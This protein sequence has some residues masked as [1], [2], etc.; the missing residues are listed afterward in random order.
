M[1]SMRRGIA[2]SIDADLLQALQAY[3]AEYV[4]RA[5]R[6]EVGDVSAADAA[7]DAMALQD[8]LHGRAPSVPAVA[9][10]RETVKVAPRPASTKAAKAQRSHEAIEPSHR[11]SSAPARKVPTRSAP[12][13]A[14]PPRATPPKRTLPPHQQ[15]SAT[16]SIRATVPAPAQQKALTPS[17]PSPPADALPGTAGLPA[18]LR[19]P[20]K[21]VLAEARLMNAVERQRLI[22][23]ARAALSAI[24]KGAFPSSVA[25][26]AGDR[27]HQIIKGAE[28][29]QMTPLPRKP[30][31]AGS[32]KRRRKRASASRGS[33]MSG[34]SL[35]PEVRRELE[36]ADQLAAD[37]AKKQSTRAMEGLPLAPRDHLFRGYGVPVSGGLPS[38]GRRS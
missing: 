33:A 11:R 18:L 37:E 17:R 13:P 5:V 7:R 14:T 2:E 26:P 10:R 28:K 25:G 4:Q 1:G 36:K 34:A 22:A 16:S 21:T 32:K 30:S 35:A 9:S 23:A 31:S 24:D 20:P 15:S 38:L 6:G 29:M 3:S 19:R 8:T 12:V 27:A